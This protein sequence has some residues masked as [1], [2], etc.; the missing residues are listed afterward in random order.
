[1]CSSPGGGVPGGNGGIVGQAPNQ[2]FRG[3]AISSSQRSGNSDSLRSA[4]EQIDAMMAE[5]A[6]TAQAYKDVEVLKKT[7]ADNKI[8]EFNQQQSSLAKAADEEQKRRAQSR[9]LL[10]GTAEQE[11]DDKYSV[12][13]PK[14]KRAT[15]ISSA[16]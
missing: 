15:L 10:S 13:P 5:K 4:F 2:L 3:V 11:A 14:A 8:A 9:T 6:K 12:K 7:Y 1:M 16:A